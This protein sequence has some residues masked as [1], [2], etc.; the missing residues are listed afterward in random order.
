[1]TAGA[2]GN[3]ADLVGNHRHVPAALIYGGADE[4]VEIN[5]AEALANEYRT[6]SPRD[7]R[8]AGLAVQRLDGPTR[9]DTAAAVATAVVA[10][11]GDISAVYLVEGE[12]ADPARGWPD[13]VAAGGLAARQGRPI[14]LARSEDVPAV[15]R[16]AMA[17][18]GTVLA[19]AV[20]GTAALSDRALAMAADPDGD[21]TGKVALHR[22]PGQTATR[23]LRRWPTTPRR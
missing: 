2:V 11:G 10:A 20:G 4:L 12:D 15:T 13:A 19:V 16:E 8:D 21:G 5:S 18:L 14:L 17:E 23:P 7:L 9:F 22:T 6:R 3:V 1:M